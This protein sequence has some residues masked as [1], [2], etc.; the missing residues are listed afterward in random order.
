MKFMT[1]SV[2]NWELH[3][4]STRSNWFLCKF[5]RP[6]ISF[7]LICLLYIVPVNMCFRGQQS[8]TRDVD[9]IKLEESLNRQIQKNDVSVQLHCC[10]CCQ[11]KSVAFDMAECFQK[12]AVQVLSQIL[13][14]LSFNQ[15]VMITE[16]RHVG[17]WNV[18]SCMKCFG[19][20]YSIVE[21]V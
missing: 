4:S 9:I 3:F 12:S 10:C 14:L 5:T 6:L 20:A 8:L 18:T 1:V 15:P 7:V 13:N 17:I 19:V 21:V 2:R 11:Q 16:K